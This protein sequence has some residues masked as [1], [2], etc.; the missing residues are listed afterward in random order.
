MNY[1]NRLQGKLLAVLQ[2]ILGQDIDEITVY[3]LYHIFSNY[4]IVLQYGN[5]NWEY[6]GA[7]AATQIIFRLHV[8]GHPQGYCNDEYWKHLTDSFYDLPL[9]YESCEAVILTQ[10]ANHPRVGIITDFDTDLESLDPEM[11]FH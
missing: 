6:L 8:I 11:F 3:V 7:S 9:E 2:E 4:K 10:I 5:R 1:I